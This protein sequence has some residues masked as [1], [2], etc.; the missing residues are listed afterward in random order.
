MLLSFLVIAAYVALNLAAITYMRLSSRANGHWIGGRSRT[1]SFYV[2]LVMNGLIIIPRML[3][4][5][6]VFFKH[7]SSAGKNYFGWPE[8]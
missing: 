2:V 8:W 6:Y 7:G 3:H 5:H 1:W 4:L